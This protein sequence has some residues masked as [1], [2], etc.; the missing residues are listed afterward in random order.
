M[1]MT[2]LASRWAIRYSKTCTGRLASRSTLASQLLAVF[3]GTGAPAEASASKEHDL[4]RFQAGSLIIEL[5]ANG[6]DTIL[7]TASTAASSI[8]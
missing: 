5:V 6:V 3:L 2:L 4:R 1:D 8:E 7:A